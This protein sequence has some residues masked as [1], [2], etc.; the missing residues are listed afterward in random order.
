MMVDEQPLDMEE[1]KEGGSN[2]ISSSKPAA[3]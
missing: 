1:D 2:P 3:N